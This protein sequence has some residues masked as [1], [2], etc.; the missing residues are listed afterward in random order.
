[1]VTVVVARFVLFSG[2]LHVPMQKLVDLDFLPR[3]RRKLATIVVKNDDFSSV[4]EDPTSYMRAPRRV[5]I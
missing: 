4:R 2:A 3:L 1:M 5:H